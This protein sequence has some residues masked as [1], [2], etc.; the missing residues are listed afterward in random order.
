LHGGALARALGVPTMLVPRYPGITSALGCVMAD[1][2]H[3][4]GLSVS[5]PLAEVD[6]TWADA[7]LAQQSAEGRALIEREAVAVTGIDVHHEA[8]LLYHG[9]THVMR[10][11][12]T[13]PG[14]DAM[15]VRAEFERIYRERFDVD[16]SEMRPMLVALR[17]TVIGRRESLA[18]SGGPSASNARTA[19]PVPTASRAVYFDGEWRDTPV[20]ARGSLETGDQI[21]GPAIVEQLDATTVLDPGDRAR[22]DALGNLIIAIAFNQRNSA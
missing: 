22:V 12:V 4:Y 15:E 11:S 9:Q 8:D 1:A 19:T 2:R 18:Q 13:S 14:F 20:F 16:L 3:D 5:R 6:G 17:T 7:V 21:Y 10:M